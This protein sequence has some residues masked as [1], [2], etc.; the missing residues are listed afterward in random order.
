MPEGG[1]AVL[2]FNQEL[3][4]PL[5]KLVSGAVFYDAG[6]VYPTVRDIRISEFRHSL[7]LGLRIAG[8][9][10]LL[11]ADYGFNLAPRPGE[12]R[13]VFTISIGQAY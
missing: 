12:S 3:R 9:L 7:G 6:N 5:L 4:F 10:G 8:P 11:R 2:I 13:G 1:E